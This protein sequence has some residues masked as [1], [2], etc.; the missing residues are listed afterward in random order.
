MAKP[1]LANSR[2]RH[3]LFA[4]TPGSF[5]PSFP[6]PQFVFRVFPTGEA[7][8]P[9][10]IAAPAANQTI[11]RHKSLSFALR[12]CTRLNGQRAEGGRNAKN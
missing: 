6:K 9:W 1:T 10:R 7:V 11:S 12:K 2:N 5:T 8:Y 4:R 3:Q